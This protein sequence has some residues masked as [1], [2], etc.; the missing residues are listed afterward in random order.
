MVA[1]DK[2]RRLR[3][4]PFTLLQIWWNNFEEKTKNVDEEYFFYSVYCM[5]FFKHPVYLQLNF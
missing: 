4:Q 3:S 1:G 2:D 5:G